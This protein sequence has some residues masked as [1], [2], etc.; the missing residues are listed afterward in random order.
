MIILSLQKCSRKLK[1]QAMENQKVCDRAE[2]RVQ[3]FGITV[4]LVTCFMDLVCM[5][6][7]ESDKIYGKYIISS[8]DCGQ[9]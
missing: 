1:I 6:I 7:S 8:M 4:L 3:V 2:T 9:S 5:T